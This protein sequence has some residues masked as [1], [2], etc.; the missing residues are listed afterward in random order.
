M[1]ITP[2][3]V[4]QSV[5]DYLEFNS[6]DP[7]AGWTNLSSVLSGVKNT[8]ALRWANTLDVKTAVE[9]VFVEKYGP[10]EAAKPKAKVSFLTGKMVARKLYA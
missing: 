2:E 4:Y 1:V 7:L 8:P 10:K 9:R 3:Q 5:A 6:S